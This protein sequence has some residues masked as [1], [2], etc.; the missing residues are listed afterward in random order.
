M[1]KQQG[2]V[3]LAEEYQFPILILLL[4]TIMVAI[5]QNIL[6]G[7]KSWKIFREMLGRRKEALSRNLSGEI[8]IKMLPSA[9]QQVATDWKDSVEKSSQ[10]RNKTFDITLAFMG[11]IVI[12]A[13][14]LIVPIAA[15]VLRWWE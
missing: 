8:H 1:T 2:A 12:E 15:T 5:I 3:L 7:G 14:L 9:K 4:V 11:I 6:F 13:L 10:Q